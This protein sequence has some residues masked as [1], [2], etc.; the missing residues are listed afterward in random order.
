MQ[1]GLTRIGSTGR[2]KCLRCMK[3]FSTKGNADR[4]YRDAHLTYEKQ[5]CSFCGKEL[6]NMSSL[7]VHIKDIHGLSQKDLQNAVHAPSARY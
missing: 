1:D 7:H 3:E 4:H 2:W 6:K 5:N